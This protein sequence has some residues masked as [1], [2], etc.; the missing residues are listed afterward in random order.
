MYIHIHMPARGAIHPMCPKICAVSAQRQ[1]SY[2]QKQHV[3]HICAETQRS[4][5]HKRNDVMIRALCLHKCQK[6]ALCRC[7]RIHCN[8]L[9][10]AF[11]ESNPTAFAQRHTNMYAGVCAVSAQRQQS[12]AQR[13]HMPHICA[14]T[15]RYAHARAETCAVL[16]IFAR[17]DVTHDVQKPLRKD[18]RICAHLCALLLHI[19]IYVYIYTYIYIYIYI[20]IY[21]YM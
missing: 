20:Y 11:T 18:L 4:A 17:I 12:Y 14:K 2:A 7:T 5:A 13:Q 10:H 15:P 1:H 19:H 16:Y 9:Q 6:H 21:M 3:S 8:T